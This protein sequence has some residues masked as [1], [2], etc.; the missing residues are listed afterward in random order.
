MLVP[1]SW[2]KDYVDFDVK[3]E[4]LASA[5][6]M[7]GFNVENIIELGKD[8]INVVAGRIVLK[9]KHP[10]ADK[11]YV[12]KVDIGDRELQIITGAQN[13]NEGDIVPVALSGAVLPGGIK[14]EDSSFRGL[15][16]Q[17]MMCSPKELNLDTKTLPD[18]Q[19]T[20]ILILPTNSPVG[21]DIKRILGLDETVL[22]I[23][24]TANRPDCL[25]IIG[26]ARETAAI[27]KKEFRFPKLEVPKGKD[28]IAQYTGA[29]LI[30][31]E[32]CQRYTIRMIDNVKIKP[33]PLWMQKRLQ[34]AG[35]RPINNIVDITNYV[36]LEIGQPLHA[37]DFDCLDDNKIVVRRAKTGEKLKTL[38]GVERVL[39][40]D[41]L[42]IADSN[43]PVGIAGVMGG[44]NSEIT[45]KTK[46]VLLESATF[47][48]ANIR[49]TSRKL[50][51]RTEA[52][53]RF[54]KGLD[55]ALAIKASE[56][57]VQLVIQT[58]SG[59]VVDGVIDIY[60]QEIKPR[61]I[62]MNSGK[63]NKLLGTNITIEEMENILNRLELKVLKKT[64]TNLTIEVPTFRN[65][66][67]R[68]A[69]LAEEIGRIYGFNEIKA[70]LPK[71]IT[72]LGKI[73]K[74]QAVVDKTKNILNS[75]G[76]SEVMTYSFISPKVFHKINIP[77]GHSLREVITIKNPLGEDY[78]IMRTTIIPNLLDVIERNINRN[79]DEI[80][81]F[82]L[83]NIYRPRD[84]LLQELPDEDRVLAIGVV[85]KADFYDL[86]GIIETLFDNLNI[87]SYDFLPAKHPTF[88]PGR[89]AE[90]LI[91]NEKIGVLGEIHPDVTEKY[92]INKRVYM[93][94]INFER[95]IEATNL[96]FKYKPLPKFPAITRDIAVIV[97]ED[98]MAGDIKKTIEAEG[99]NIVEKIELFDVYKGRQIPDGYKSL[100]YSITFRSEERT[101]TDEDVTAIQEKILSE[102]EKKFNAQLR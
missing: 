37:F 73:N 6:T 45:E 52:S 14:I 32:L 7:A 8:I 65:D 22:E 69:D 59:E 55:P 24:V 11:L 64:D 10:N 44:E 41:I 84:L 29:E 79:I 67:A 58:Q 3:T 16:S 71:G 27:L 15:T 1:I 40:E 13:I 92:E 75:C 35:I 97:N 90:I 49:K 100:A 56:R 21:E 62:S 93:C 50:G 39:D 82:E 61:R 96:T 85:G 33:S 48:Y 95:V 63:V 78:S 19:K 9:E 70:T 51:V 57:F 88:H 18:D 53:A 80:K 23:E 42:V 5:L 25:S 31:P 68:E 28:H 12:C 86:K 94:E 2:L 89:T 83:G 17:G 46:R 99:G 47:N 43:K 98:I 81:I 30:A 54:E 101:L 36:M 26:I 38:D 74:G 66:I 76:L 34:A 77:E 91:K 4:D 60:P 102:L 20:G 87:D 72:T